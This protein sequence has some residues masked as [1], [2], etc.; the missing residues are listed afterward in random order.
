[1]KQEM[2]MAEGGGDDAG[3][4]RLKVVQEAKGGGAV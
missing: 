3:G 1:M 4:E 2:K